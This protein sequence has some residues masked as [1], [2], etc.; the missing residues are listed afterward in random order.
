MTPTN[1]LVFRVHA[2][3]RMFERGIKVEDV[4]SVVTDGEVIQ[5]YLEDKPYPSR[6]VLGWRG[7]RPI[8]TVIAED[9]EAGILIVVTAYE[10]DP[11]QWDE[12]FKRKVT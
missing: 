5:T 11:T 10:P 6:L 4:R 3:Q 8:H 2:L 9:T 1:R 7:P 12:G